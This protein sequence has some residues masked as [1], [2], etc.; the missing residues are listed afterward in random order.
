[1]S[2]TATEL[3]ETGDFALG[4]C[5]ECKREV[6]SYPDWEAAGDALVRRCTHCDERLGGELR[7]VEV[8]DL[9][10]LGYSLESPETERACAS[11]PTGGC[12]K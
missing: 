6:L 9:E 3:L 12:R 4:H 10:S 7:W 2:G 1:M 11:C 5:R 8:G